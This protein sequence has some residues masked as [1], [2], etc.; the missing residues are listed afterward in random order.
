MSRVLHSLNLIL[1]GGVERTRMSLLEHLPPMYEHAAVCVEI[2][3]DH[4]ASQMRK[5]LD[6]L[7]E[8][9]PVS[10]VLNPRRYA[11]TAQLARRWRPDIIHGA[12]I[13]G[14]TVAA[15][16]GRLVRAPVVVMEETSDPQA[17]SPNGDRLSRA[18]ARLADHCIGVSP[19]VGRYL[20]DTLGVSE[21]KVSVINNG[22][23]LP[24]LPGRTEAG[25]VKGELGIPADCLVVG[26]VGRM[27]DDS[28]KRFGDLLRAIGRVDAAALPHLVLVGDGRERPG[29]E[30]LARDLGIAD[31]VHFVGFQAE[32]GHYYALMDIFALTS[33]RE[34]FGLV[35]AEAMRCGLPVVA[36]NVGGIPDVVTHNQ[37]GI[38]VPP[39]DIPAITNALQTLIDN[40]DLRH[41]MGAAGKQRADTHFSAERYVNDV[42]QLYQ[43]LL[44]NPRR[45]RRRYRDA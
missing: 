20:T 28:V 32:P 27:H 43:H 42:H 3:D 22:V 41:R 5:R 25:R 2:E 26:S 13:E 33:E 34:A 1:P 16:A 40:P 11:R 35:N 21:S 24:S 44:A 37:T 23:E 30:R 14:Y 12:I 29:L 4:Y 15:I 45:Q 18:M 17:R 31:R 36:T 10:S 7:E 19:G 38:L 6:F 8:L 39:R 9:G